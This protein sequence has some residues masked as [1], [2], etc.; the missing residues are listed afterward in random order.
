M[1]G[2]VILG[3]SRSNGNTRK[4][5]DLFIDQTRYDLIDLRDHK[6]EHFDYDIVKSE[7][8]FIPLFKRII[9]NYNL[10]VFATPVY[11]YSMSGIMKV[12]FDRITECLGNEKELG[13]KLRGMNMAMISCSYRDD[14]DESFALPFSESA[15]YLG[16]NYLGDIH[17]WV[18]DPKA[19][20]KEVLEKI[21]ALAITLE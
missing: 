13:R 15:S 21:E 9:E 19:I 3:S 11:W 20:K 12:F 14:R 2:V 7:D 8:D 4:I 17:T 1:K 16:M 6:I 18:D 5:V 10:I